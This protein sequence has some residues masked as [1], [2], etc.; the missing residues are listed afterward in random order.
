M[1]TAIVTAAISKIIYHLHA[2]P[3]PRRSAEL[4]QFTVSFPAT[5]VR[6]RKKL[7]ALRAAALPLRIVVALLPPPPYPLAGHGATVQSISPPTVSRRFTRR[8]L[9]RAR[10]AVYFPSLPPSIIFYYSRAVAL[11]RRIIGGGRRWAHVH[12]FVRDVNDAPPSRGGRFSRTK[13]IAAAAATASSRV[14]STAPQRCC[15]QAAPGRVSKT[16]PRTIA[17]KQNR[18]CYII[19]YAY[20]K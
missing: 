18:E 9:V 8:V 1:K 13:W 11:A 15:R 20:W 4:K 14:S 6:S 3:P 10:N 17:D 19:L 2:A 16:K 7:S 12:N 5:A